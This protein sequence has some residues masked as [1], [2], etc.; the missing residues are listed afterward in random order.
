MN[1]KIK[2]GKKKRKKLKW[3]WAALNKQL[4]CP[5]CKHSNKR[6]LLTA[7]CCN[8][9]W[10]KVTGPKGARVCQTFEKRSKT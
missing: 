10:P 9:E 4:G 3:G 6:L 5:E 8:I 1:N 7:M 2:G